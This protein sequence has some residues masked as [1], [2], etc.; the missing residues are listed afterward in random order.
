MSAQREMVVVESEG[1][2]GR[3]T[4]QQWL[5]RPAAEGEQG[6]G[7]RDGP[8]ACHPVLWAPIMNWL[9]VHMGISTRPSICLSSYLVSLRGV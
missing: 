1:R 5:E 8:T 2:T 7:E 3:W 4:P 6:Q 9:Q